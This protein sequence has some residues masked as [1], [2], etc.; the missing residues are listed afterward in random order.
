MKKAEQY[1]KT[2]F[3]KFVKRQYGSLDEFAKA[4]EISVP[5]C[6]TYIKYPIRMRISEFNKITDQTQISAQQL[7]II[8]QHQ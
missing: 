2:E 8:I 6:R 5:T 3:G 1:T 7:W 4:L